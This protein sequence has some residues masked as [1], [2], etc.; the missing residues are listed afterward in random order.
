[1]QLYAS[2]W[3]E[4]STDA[5]QRL[6]KVLTTDVDSA[7]AVADALVAESGVEVCP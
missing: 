1:M 3:Q 7:S 5:L 6:A 2:H 4:K